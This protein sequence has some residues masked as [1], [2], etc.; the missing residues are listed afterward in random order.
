[1]PKNKTLQTVMT[2]VVVAIALI[3]GAYVFGAVADTT[4]RNMET[5]IAEESFQV[6]IGSYVALNESNI[7]SGS[8][9]IYNDQ[10]TLV[11]KTGNYTMNYT[12]G[13]IKALSDTA[14]VTDE[15]W[16]VNIGSWV[17][18][19]N[20]NFVKD[21]E[22]VKNSSGTQM[23]KGTDYEMNYTDGSIKALSGSDLTDANSA[24]ISYDHY[25]TTLL[26]GTTAT[27]NYTY[28]H[29]IA[30]F[31]SVVSNFGSA[32][33]LLAVGLIVLAA[34]FILGILINKFTSNKKY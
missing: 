2:V 20:N 6:E 24:T 28:S 32:I 12:D 22:I 30:G 18:L 25:N 9:D 4:P 31:S 1:M 23:T 11:K 27:A 19:N 10:G 34:A 13:S 15:S 3:I 26:N 5:D 14:S 7:V 33:T 29:Y 17:K 16:T 8:E 21:S